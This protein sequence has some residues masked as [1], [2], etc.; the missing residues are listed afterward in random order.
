[1]RRF[2]LV[3][4]AFCFLALSVRGQVFTLWP[5]SGGGS[6]NPLEAEIFSTEPVIINGIECEMKLGLVY[7]GLH[8]LAALL[9]EH[10][11]DA[12]T[13]AAGNSLMMTL[14]AENGW[15][16]RYLYI[17]LRHGM[18][19]LQIS[20]KVPEKLPERFTW[21]RQLPILPHATPFRVMVFP[22]RDAFYGSFRYPPGS[23][24]EAL[25]QITAAAGNDW[26]RTAHE[27]ANLG[28]ASGEILIRS[29]PSSIMLVNFTQ[30][31]TGIVYIRPLKK[32]SK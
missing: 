25:E 23:T 10:F 2:A 1:M 4:F 13:V 26:V 32:E 18:P 19:V 16:Q 12:Q 27:S 11:R 24:A 5:S 22:K 20:M 14:P 15:R 9:R 6:D 28:R 21:P 31:G 30:E 7:R 29:N 8:D 3:L 17:A